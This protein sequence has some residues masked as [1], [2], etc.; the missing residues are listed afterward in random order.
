MYE[1]AHTLSPKIVIVKVMS[2]V[3]L[4]HHTMSP[5]LAIERLKESK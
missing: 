2:V 4:M 1:I 5:E 3:Y